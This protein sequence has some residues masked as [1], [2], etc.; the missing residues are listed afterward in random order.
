M[1]RFNKK[2]FSALVLALLCIVLFTNNIA[3]AINIKQ[4][5]YATEHN[6]NN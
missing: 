1:I 2:S 6:S 4:K 3:E 5:G